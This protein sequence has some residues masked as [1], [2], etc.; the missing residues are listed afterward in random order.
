LYVYI[1]VN[2]TDASKLGV[3]DEDRRTP[4]HSAAGEK[5]TPLWGLLASTRS[6]NFMRDTIAALIGPF[7]NGGNNSTQSAR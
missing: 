2:T 5:L 3:A 6:W 4:S 1:D 7:Q